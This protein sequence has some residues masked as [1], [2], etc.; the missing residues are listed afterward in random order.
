MSLSSLRGSRW[1]RSEGFKL[2]ALFLFSGYNES[3]L[4]DELVTRFEFG[5]SGHQ[6]P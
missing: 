5:V 4:H 2:G 1:G 3:L 6:P